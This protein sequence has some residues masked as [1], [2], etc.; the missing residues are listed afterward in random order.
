MEEVRLGFDGE[1]RGGR[2]AWGFVVRAGGLAVARGWAAGR[3]GRS[4]LGAALLALERGLEFILDS[5]LAHRSVVAGSDHPQVVGA[6]LRPP[7]SKRRSSVSKHLADLIGQFEALRFDGRH[8]R[9]N[10]EARALARLGLAQF[11]LGR[12]S[13]EISDDRGFSESAQKDNGR[14]LPGG[15]PEPLRSGTPDFYALPFEVEELRQVLHRLPFRDREVLRLRYAPEGGEPQT[16]RQIGH[17][18]RICPQRVRQ[19]LD[20]GLRRLWWLAVR[21]PAWR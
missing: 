14:A 17:V 10:Q 5:P 20:R 19:V 1:R 15:D 12:R 3:T 7:S 8:T 18:F 21:F 4:R 2:A 16:L 13:F 6:V 11:E 9:A